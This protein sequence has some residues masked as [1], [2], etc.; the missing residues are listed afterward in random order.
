MCVC[1]CYNCTV[2]STGL[3]LSRWIKVNGKI[4]EVW[5]LLQHQ[6]GAC[7]VEQGGVGA[8][9]WELRFNHGWIMA[10]AQNRGVS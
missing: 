2:F 1:M 10:L 7:W 4:D 8:F 5:M 9:K 6:G 3:C